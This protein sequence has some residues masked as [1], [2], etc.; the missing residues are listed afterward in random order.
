MIRAVIDT[1]V[2]IRYL[3]KP[4][5]A[6]KELIEEHWLGD[7]IELVTAPELIAELQGVLE[8]DYIQVL[9]RPEEGQTLLDALSQKAEILPSLGKVPPYTRDPK[10]DIFVGCALAGDADYL[11]TVDEDILVLDAVGDVCMVT[12][13]DFCAIHQQS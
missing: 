11:I 10:D 1:S 7:K 13:V 8:R 3:I 9:I 6:I 5:V 12:P 4:S 2:F